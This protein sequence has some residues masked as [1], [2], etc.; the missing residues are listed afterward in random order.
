VIEPSDSLASYSTSIN[1]SEIHSLRSS[2]DYNLEVVD[3]PTSSAGQEAV[4]TPSSSAGQDSTSSAMDYL[5]PPASEHSASDGGI[6]NISSG[7]GQDS[8]GTLG[9]MSREQLRDEIRSVFGDA[10]LGIVKQMG[11][12]L[13]RNV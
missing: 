13:E 4:D 12:A 11:S 1:G 9:D 6:S 8:T 3:T 7:G 2:D 10:L 5:L